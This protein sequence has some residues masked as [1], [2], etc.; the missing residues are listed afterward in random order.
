MGLRV[1]EHHSNN[2]N[3]ANGSFF[4]TLAY[5]VLGKTSRW[6]ETPPIPLV[7]TSLT[8]DHLGVARLGD[9]IETAADFHG[10]G[11]GLAIANCYVSCGERHPARASGVYKTINRS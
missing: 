1:L 5:V 7:T 8:D 4:A 6:S 9:C 3:L 2:K 11:Y 10:A